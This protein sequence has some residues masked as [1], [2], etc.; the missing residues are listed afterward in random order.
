MDKAKE[1]KHFP[2]EIYAVASDTKL[3]IVLP[4]KLRIQYATIDIFR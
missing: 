2:S 1:L 3:R 4:Y